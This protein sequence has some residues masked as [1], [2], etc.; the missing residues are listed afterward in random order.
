MEV[1]WAHSGYKRSKSINEF[2]FD[3]EAAENLIMAWLRF[4]PQGTG[5][6][7]ANDYLSFV[8]NLPVPLRM[9]NENFFRKC[10]L[11][12]RE[13]ETLFSGSYP[14][15]KE[16][17]PQLPFDP[18]ERDIIL[19]NNFSNFSRPAYFKNDDGSLK[20]SVVQYFQFFRIYNLNVYVDKK[21]W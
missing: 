18:E 9:R 13:M 1:G 8:A 6:I 2:V 17:F 19:F 5:C 14:Y 15:T 12:H 10:N 21:Q 7:R 11:L 4:D 16:A 3:D 20:L